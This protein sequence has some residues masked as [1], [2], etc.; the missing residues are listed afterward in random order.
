MEVRVVTRIAVPTFQNIL[1]QKIRYLRS[2]LTEMTITQR[3]VKLDRFDL[4]YVRDY[5][6]KSTIRE[7]G[8][9]CENMFN[10]HH[11]RKI[12]IV[13]QQECQS[14]WGKLSYNWQG[15][16][17]WT[18]QLKVVWWHMR[19]HTISHHYV[20]ILYQPMQIMPI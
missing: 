16:W 20:T 3:K 18:D 1:G 14:N 6:R 7:C 12:V 17:D 5:F 8:Y 11:N 4:V 13:F 19:S 15:M 2:S 9:S 10:Y